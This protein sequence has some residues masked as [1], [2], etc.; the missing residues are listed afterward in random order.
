MWA[1]C[2]PRQ[3]RYF[4]SS[5]LCSWDGVSQASAQLNLNLPPVPLNP[6][7]VCRQLGDAGEDQREV[8]GAQREGEGG[9]GRAT[10]PHSR[11]RLGER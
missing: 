6:P 10:D 1:S 3:P 5:A 7:P 11:A 4:F 8:E 2:I 9:P